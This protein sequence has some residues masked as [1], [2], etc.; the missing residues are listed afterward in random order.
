[1]LRI[2]GGWRLGVVQISLPW[3]PH[4][5]NWIVIERECICWGV[6]AAKV[7]GT[8]MGPQLPI[9]AK[10]TWV[11]S[12]IQ[13]QLSVPVI[14]DELT[15]WVLKV[16][17]G[18]EGTATVSLPWTR[19]P[20]AVTATP[21]GSVAVTSID[22][23]AKDKSDCSYM[24]HTS[25]LQVDP[26]MVSGSGSVGQP[27]LPAPHLTSWMVIVPCWDSTSSLPAENVVW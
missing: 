2:I 12:L 17:P 5:T 3:S 7:T 19:M 10:D 1:M 13:S 11:P 8:V 14:T 23:G 9:A 25:P 6:W 21:S 15:C 24:L 22:S 20:S 4:L 27:G 18:A 16:A 26:L